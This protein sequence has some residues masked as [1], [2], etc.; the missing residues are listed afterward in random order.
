[1]KPMKM[2]NAQVLYMHFTGA[3][4]RLAIACFF[5]IFRII[6]QFTCFISLI[7]ITWFFATVLVTTILK[8]VHLHQYIQ[9]CYREV[10]GKSFLENYGNPLQKCT[11]LCPTVNAL[12]DCQESTNLHNDS[13]FLSTYI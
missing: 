5:L 7:L 10:K 11:I 13:K 1:M 3:T 4:L 12:R 2:A 8:P 6:S 9:H